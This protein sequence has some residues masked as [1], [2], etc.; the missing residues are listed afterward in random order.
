MKGTDMEEQSRTVDIRFSDLWTILKRCWILMLA[1]FM[2]VG[3]GTFIGMKVT[4]TPKY[5]SKAV[6]YVT[7]GVADGKDVTTSNVSIATN[8]VK[9]FNELITSDVILEGVNEKADSMLTVNQ[10]KGMV[11]VENPTGTRVLYIYVTAGDRA[12]AQMLANTFA[13]VT[14]DKFNSMYVEDTA[15][16]GKT[17]NMVKVFGEANYPERES[18]PVSKLVVLLI[19]F[20]CAV[21]VYL[22]YF[23]LFLLDDKIN[24]ADDVQKYLKLNI[25]GEI[26]NRA[27]VG[28][29]KGKYGYY[30]AYTS[31]PSGTS[32]STD[33]AGK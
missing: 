12:R 11:S 2:V 31:Q 29:K 13:E 10:I 4:H 33:S 9:D 16:G 14:C 5:T 3:L 24:D 28:K 19:A 21:L 6:V 27:D 22:V 1:V 8:L 23:V 20:A 17:Q 18:N 15:D 26:P 25:L 30:A 32:A 7:G